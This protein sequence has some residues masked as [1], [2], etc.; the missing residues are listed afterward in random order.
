MAAMTSPVAPTP[1]IPVLFIF[2][3]PFVKTTCSFEQNSVKTLLNHALN[4]KK[5]INYVK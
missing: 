4:I 1:K 2:Y 3:V 5:L